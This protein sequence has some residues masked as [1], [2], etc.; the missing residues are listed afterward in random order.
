VET[1]TNFNGVDLIA[2]RPQLF[3][4]L[5]DSGGVRTAGQ[6]DKDVAPDSHYIAAFERCRSKHSAYRP[7]C[8]DR[9]RKAVA[10][11]APARGSH[12]RDDRDLLEHYEGVLY[13]HSVGHFRLFGE[14]NYANTQSCQRSFVLLVLFDSKIDRH[15]LPRK[16]CQLAGR[17]RMAYGARQSCQ[18][19]GQFRLTPASPGRE[20]EIRPPF[21]L[22]S[23]KPF[24]NGQ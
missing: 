23:S 3:R 22:A 24:K 4:Q 9:V 10:F 19:G 1:S 6:S 5:P 8:R 16:P 21:V 14:R 13:K 7:E 18:H 12:T 2:E 15:L 20:H 11:R 17:E